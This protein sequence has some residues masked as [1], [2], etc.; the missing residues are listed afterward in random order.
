MQQKKQHNNTHKYA[1]THTPTPTHTPH[2]T[3][4]HITKRLSCVCFNSSQ[5][6]TELEN[7]NLVR[8][9]RTLLQRDKFVLRKVA[10]DRDKHYQAEETYAVFLFNDLLIIAKKKSLSSKLKQLT[11][12][13]LSGVTPNLMSGGAGNEVGF[14]LEITPASVTV[15]GNETPSILFEFAASSAEAERW[16][17]EIVKAK[18]RFLRRSPALGS[19]QEQQQQ[20]Q[21]FL[22]PQNPSCAR[23]NTTFDH[24][25]NRRLRCFTCSSAVCASCSK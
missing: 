23:C 16:V 24:S 17:Q 11:N 13:L 2:T 22:P 25:E 1:H 3:H 21:Q 12:V 10:N 15:G 5:V 9:G 20:Q 7:K 14:T 18:R 6:A 19:L 4:T 8:S